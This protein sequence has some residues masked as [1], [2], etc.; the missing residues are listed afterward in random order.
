VVDAGDELGVRLASCGTRERYGLRVAPGDMNMA[1]EYAPGT[2][3]LWRW[4]SSP[5]Q[6]TLPVSKSTHE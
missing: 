5:K 6:A 4:R 3:E 2:P 1:S